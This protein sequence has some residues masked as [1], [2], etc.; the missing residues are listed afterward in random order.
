MFCNNSVI[1]TVGLYG[2]CRNTATYYEIATREFGRGGVGGLMG[3]EPESIHHSF[4]VKFSFSLYDY[5]DRK[6]IANPRV[7]GDRVFTVYW[8][9]A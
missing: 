8:R 1:L 7:S 9:R 2:S 5:G 4:I 6:S 3:I